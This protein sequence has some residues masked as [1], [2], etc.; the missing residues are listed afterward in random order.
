MVVWDPGKKFTVSEGMVHHKHKNTAYL[1][2]ELFG[3]VSQ[4]WIGGIKVCDEGKFLHLNKGKLITT[5][6]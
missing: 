2:E 3:V 5:N 1:H 6:E 4:T